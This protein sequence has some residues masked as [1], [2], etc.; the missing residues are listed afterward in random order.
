MFQATGLLGAVFRKNRVCA[1][2]TSR[3]NALQTSSTCQSKGRDADHSPEVSTRYVTR[4]PIER[5]G[6]VPTTDDNKQL[7]KPWRG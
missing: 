6:K 4:K 1:T 2:V 5:P 7:S 3:S